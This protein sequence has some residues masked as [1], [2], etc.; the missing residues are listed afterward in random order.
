[1]INE[2]VFICENGLEMYVL[3]HPLRACARTY[4]AH[5]EVTLYRIMIRRRDDFN[6][7]SSSTYKKEPDKTRWKHE[8]KQQQQHTHIRT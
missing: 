2:C 7:R 3:L 6:S 8:E 1:M 5:K 4:T